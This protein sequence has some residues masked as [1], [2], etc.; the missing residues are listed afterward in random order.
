MLDLVVRDGSL[1][2]FRGSLIFI[3]ELVIR[4]SSLAFSLCGHFNLSSA[5]L[6]F[7]NQAQMLV[8]KLGPDHAYSIGSGP[9]SQ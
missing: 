8:T 4:G 6:S 1:A 3:P 9:D 7:F 5:P 2:F